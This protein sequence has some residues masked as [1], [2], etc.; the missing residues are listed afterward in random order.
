MIVANF[1]LSGGLLCIEESH[2]VQRQLS[3]SVVCLN[4]DILWATLLLLMKLER[5]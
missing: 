1:L 2:Y 5:L 4:A 3:A